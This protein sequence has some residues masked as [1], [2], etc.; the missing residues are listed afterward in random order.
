MNWRWFNIFVR[1]I[2]LIIII[3]IMNHRANYDSWWVAFL[4]GAMFVLVSWHFE[5]CR[6]EY[7][8]ERLK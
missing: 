1:D 8:L 7:E 5:D 6:K 3:C 4:A 2:M